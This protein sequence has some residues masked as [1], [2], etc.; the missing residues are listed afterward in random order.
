MKIMIACG[1]TGGHLFPGL[2]V[3]ETLVARG[4]QVKLLVSPKTV[5]QTAWQGLQSRVSHLPLELA[6]ITA[7][8]LNG[9]SRWIHFWL[10]SARAVRQCDAL[11]T[12]YQP[13]AVLA[14]GG[15]VSPPA[16]LAAARPGRRRIARVIHESNA[17]PGR[18]NRWM[19]RLADH[20]A[21]GLAECATHFDGRPVTVT[22][23]PIRERLR[24]GQ[25]RPE[26]WERLGLARDRLTV[27]VMGG[28]QG[29]QAL[30]E[31][32]PCVLPWLDGW[33]ERVQFV[34]L[35]GPQDETAL[36]AAY[37]ANGFRAQVMSFC[38]EMEWPY[39]VADVVVSRAGA[40]ALTEIAAFGLPAVLVPYPHAAGNH[41]WRNAQLF[42]RAGAARV[43]DQNDLLTGL[44]AARGERLAEALTA[45]LGDPARRGA[46]AEAARSLA[47]PDAAERVVT[48]LE[49]YGETSHTPAEPATA[50]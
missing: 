36:R 32:I 50:R 14:M 42:V 25:R 44:H 49:Q 38:H 10:Q 12:E 30:N 39:S 20:V 13:D 28:S 46:M 27:L 19:R 11:V 17:V 45:L 6:T 22:G 24:G 9:R 8:G 15:F 23:T 7:I 31:A 35:A 3:A 48:I 37:A 18:A 34:H 43:L 2:A 1:G 29:A 41:Q 47:R 21:V 40:A 26:A 16:I 5:D 4:H 33:A